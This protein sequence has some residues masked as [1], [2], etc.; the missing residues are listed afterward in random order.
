MCSS[1]KSTVVFFLATATATFADGKAGLIDDCRYTDD[2]AAQ[3]AWRPMGGSAPA[4][5]S[6]SVYPAAR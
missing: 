3:K 2:A 5:A 4:A 1:L 6:G